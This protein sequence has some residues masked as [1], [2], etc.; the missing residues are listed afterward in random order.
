MGKVFGNLLS[1]P[2][3]VLGK[4]SIVELRL[5]TTPRDTAAYATAT[6]ELACFQKVTVVQF[7]TVLASFKGLIKIPG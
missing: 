4:C 5:K 1:F 3:E 6:L 7:P 2:S